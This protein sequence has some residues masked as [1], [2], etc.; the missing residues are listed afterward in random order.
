VN[1][2]IS[3]NLKLFFLAVKNSPELRKITE[4]NPGDSWGDKELNQMSLDS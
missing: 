3:E 2:I 1:K 4:K